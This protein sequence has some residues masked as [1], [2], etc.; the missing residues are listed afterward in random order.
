[1]SIELQNYKII[2][3][4]KETVMVCNTCAFDTLLHTTAHM[5]GMDV[6]YK[7]TIQDTDDRYMQLAT[8]IVS[9]GKITKNEYTE[10]ASFLIK[11]SLF[12]QSKYTRNFQSLNAMCNAAHLAKYT[13]ASLPNLRRSKN[14][15]TCDYCNERN[16]KAISVNVNVL[17]HKGF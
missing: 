14:C 10:E 5:I 13:F 4:Q 12:Q 6:E 16:F 7:R 1:M 3:L 8:K 11:I 9:R 2:K 17:L 15:E